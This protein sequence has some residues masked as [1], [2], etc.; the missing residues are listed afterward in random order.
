VIRVI[1]TSPTERIKRVLSGYGFDSFDV[2]EEGFRATR[3]IQEAR[4]RSYSPPIAFNSFWPSHGLLGGN[5]F[6]TDGLATILPE[7]LKE[8]H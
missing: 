7:L 3:A 4:K 1:G 8:K 2:L 6:V 5:R